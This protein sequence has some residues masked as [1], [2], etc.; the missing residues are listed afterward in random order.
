MLWKI[1]QT[2]HLMNGKRSQLAMEFSAAQSCSYGCGAAASRD[3]QRFPATCVKLFLPPGASEQ[4][5][6][7]GPEGAPLCDIYQGEETHRRVVT[8]GIWGFTPPTPDELALLQPLPPSPHHVK[9]SSPRCLPST[10]LFCSRLWL[11]QSLQWPV[12]TLRNGQI[13]QRL[14]SIQR[15]LGIRASVTSWGGDWEWQDS[16]EVFQFIYEVIRI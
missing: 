7:S 16:A 10:W 9:V 3:D 12:L 1:R 8:E 6:P 13:P 15:G 5:R 4:P 14:S 2:A 11:K